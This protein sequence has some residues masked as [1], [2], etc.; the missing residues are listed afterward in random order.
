MP[1][2]V[3]D[4]ETACGSSLSELLGREVAT[5]Q[6]LGGGRNSRVYAL[7]CHG[8]AKYVAKHY[9][10]PTPGGRDT[11]GS[12]FQGLK[13]LWAQEERSIPRPILADRERGLAVFEFVEGSKLGSAEANRKDL[14]QAVSFL[15]RLK[16]LSKIP[17]A[18]EL[19]DAAEACFSFATV[20][21]SLQTRLLRLSCLDETDAQAAVLQAFL[22]G[23]FQP[24][25]AEIVA[26]CRE[27]ANRLG[28]SFDKEL[29]R[30]FRTLS[31]SDFGFHNAIRRPNGQLVFLDFEYFGWDDPAKMVS[32]FLLHPAMELTHEVKHKFFREIVAGLAS[33]QL[34]EDR[35][36]IVCPLF[37]LK[38]CL[39]LLNEFV[40]RDLARRTFASDGGMDLAEVRDKQLAKA[41]KMLDTAREYHDKFPF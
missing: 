28:L 33:D 12:E 20:V 24:A 27:A 8:G 32:D 10:A 6:R 35:I 23:S 3:E 38:W 16:K 13:F 15:L 7:E 14:E 30:E 29:G 9:F 31:P 11:L 25:L 18:V 2:R 4:L 36:R 17:E 39:I 37:A 22:S 1:P 26:D 5:A 21:D 40:P 34:L 41:R 19:G